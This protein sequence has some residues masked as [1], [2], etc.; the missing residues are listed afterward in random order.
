MSKLI[1]W[2]VVSVKEN[3][4]IVEKSYKKVKKKIKKLGKKPVMSKD[5][6][7]TGFFAYLLSD[8]Q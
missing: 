4:K 1:S 6:D 2:N 3:S 5:V 7:I 8:R